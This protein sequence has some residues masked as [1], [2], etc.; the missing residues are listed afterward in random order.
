MLQRSLSEI[1][2]GWRVPVSLIVWR[3]LLDP[4]YDLTWEEKVKRTRRVMD[5]RRV[6]K[7]RREDGT[8]Q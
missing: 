6:G 4:S 2:N 7:K 3:I 1:Y 8:A 5:V